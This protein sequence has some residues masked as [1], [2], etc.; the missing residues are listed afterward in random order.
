MRSGID[1]GCIRFGSSG[2]ISETCAER[3]RRVRRARRNRS[4][5][6]FHPRPLTLVDEPHSVDVLSSRTV[7]SSPPSFVR[8]AA[9]DSSVMSG[10]SSSKP[11]KR[12]GAGAMYT[13]SRCR[14]APQRP[15]RPCRGLQGRPRPRGQAGPLGHLREEGPR[16]VAGRTSSGSSR[17]G[18]RVFRRA[19]SPTPARA[20]RGTGSWSRS[21]TRRSRHPTARSERGPGSRA[22]FRQSRATCSPAV[23]AA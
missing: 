19:Q 20:G 12:P 15:L 17:A 13:D 14:N 21:C 1:P 10:A 23:T 9:N 18:S 5:S 2:S 22:A 7:P 3:L 11:D 16:V 8:F 4:V 6:L